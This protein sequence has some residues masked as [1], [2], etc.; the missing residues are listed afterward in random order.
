MRRYRRIRLI[1][2]FMLTAISL[3]AC[4]FSVEVLSVGT[5][6]SHPPTELTLLPIT[7]QTPVPITLT[8]PS[9][10]PTLISIRDNTLSMLEIFM[11]VGG[12]ELLRSAAFTPDST[13]LATAGGNVEDF[14]IH[15]WDVASG[16]SIG[17]LDGHTGIVWG[18]AFSSDGQMLVSVSSDKTAK[19]WDWRNRTLLKSLDLPGEMVSVS[20]SPDG[21]ILAVGGVDEPLGDLQNAAIWTYFVDSWNPLL[22]FQEYWNITALTYSPDGKFLIGGGTSRNVQVWRTSDGTSIFTL[23]HPH[24]V[25]DAAVSP[26]GSMVATATCQITLGDDC[27]E[28]AVWLWNLSNG[29]LIDRDRLRHFPNAVESVAFSVDGSTLIAAS[30]DGTLRVYAT[31]DYQELFEATPPGGTG[32]LALSPD[33][34]LLATGGANGVVHLWKVVNRP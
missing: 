16:E 3:N 14:A 33:G 18:V 24:Q 29:R 5:P 6:T 22:K 13:V 2:S 27:T 30:R 23:S 26:D 28:G 12:G 11:N 21:Q 8:P 34:G 10:T 7:T 17:K 15:L 32:I 20:F 9:A 19:I 4:I 25:S 31:S 1:T